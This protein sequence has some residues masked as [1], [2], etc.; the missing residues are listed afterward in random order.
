MIW[1]GE[2]PA[3]QLTID[4]MDPNTASLIKKVKKLLDPNWI[5]NPGH[6]DV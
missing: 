4:K 5:M 2:T 6:W 1:K 3:Q